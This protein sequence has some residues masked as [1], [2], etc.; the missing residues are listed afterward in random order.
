[1]SAGV[2]AAVRVCV[3]GIDRP[4]RSGQ[5]PII[6]DAN[7]FKFMLLVT[8]ARLL[9]IPAALAI[10]VVRTSTGSPTDGWARFHLCC[11][12]EKPCT[13]VHS[14]AAGHPLHPTCL[15]WRHRLRRLP[16][17]FPKGR[18]PNPGAAAP[19]GVGSVVWWPRLAAH[20]AGA[21]GHL[22]LT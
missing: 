18:V 15:V 11:Q 7:D 6:A 22:R 17:R 13:Q 14:P 8:L 12:G 21:T 10:Q 4:V 19:V 9:L 20:A 5:A 2:L 16:G 1:M 3:Y